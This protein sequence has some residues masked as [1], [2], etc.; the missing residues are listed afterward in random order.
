MRHVGSVFW[1]VMVSETPKFYRNTV[2]G[3]SL[4]D[5]NLGVFG[6]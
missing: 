5:G 6:L 2:S 4:F 1:G 3:K